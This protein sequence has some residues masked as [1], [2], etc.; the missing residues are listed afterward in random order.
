M[1][2][3]PLLKPGNIDFLHTILCLLIA[4]IHLAILRDVSLYLVYHTQ[5]CGG[6]IMTC[7]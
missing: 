2:N 1:T 4:N 7:S 5:L 3:I 6:I